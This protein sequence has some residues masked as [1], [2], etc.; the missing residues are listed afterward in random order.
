MSATTEA[1]SP[2]EIEKAIRDCANRIAASVQVC[3]DR[4]SEFME[5]DRE[6]EWAFHWAADTY[7][8]PAHSKKSHAVLSTKKERERRDVADA[9]Y[10]YADRLSKAIEIELRAWQS[11]GA[12][13][14]E[15]YRVAGR[16]ES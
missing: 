7:E 14:R 4:Y 2:V 13:I 16:G 6:Y 8:G 5:A 10:R 15:A 9:A 1:L 11:V 12:S 3:A